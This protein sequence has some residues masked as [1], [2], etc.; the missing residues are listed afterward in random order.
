MLAVCQDDEDV[1]DGFLAI[2]EY[3]EVV[4]VIH[5]ATGMNALHVAC[6]LGQDEM[7]RSLVV[8]GTLTHGNA[9]MC[10]PKCLAR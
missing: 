9:L 10:Q 4:D 1:L 3:A 7:I 8:A 5:E 6:T 2:P